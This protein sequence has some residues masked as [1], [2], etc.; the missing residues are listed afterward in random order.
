MQLTKTFRIEEIHGTS[1]SN[2][3]F[4]LILNK[5]DS[6]FDDIQSNLIMNQETLGRHGIVPSLALVGM[7]IEC[8]LTSRVLDINS[9]APIFTDADN[10]RADDVLI[11][12]IT[13]HE[14]WTQVFRSPRRKD[15]TYSLHAK[16]HD[17]GGGTLSIC[18]CPFYD[19]VVN[20]TE[21]EYGYLIRLPPLT[22]FEAKFVVLPA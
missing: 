14:S 16:S 12:K 18:P 4:R 3:P 11:E 20:L 1:I 9:N 21:E 13:K 17:G 2:A 8:Q 15:V 7:Y 19:L 10:L 5:V 22:V 6:P